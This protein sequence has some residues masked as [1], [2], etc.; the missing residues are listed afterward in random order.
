M[1]HK[2]SISFQGESVKKE[3]R[4]TGG[5]SGY[6]NKMDM[7]KFQIKEQEKRVDMSRRHLPPKDTSVVPNR[8]ASTNA[9]SIQRYKFNPA[10][11]TERKHSF[12]NYSEMNSARVYRRPL[13]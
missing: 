8:S 4:G 7:N 11:L 10:S 3:G 13:D 1:S 5:S 12:D 9:S 2:P 6:I